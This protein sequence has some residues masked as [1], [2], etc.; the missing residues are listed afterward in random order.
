VSNI[1]LSPSS[2]VYIAKGAVTVSL[3]CLLLSCGGTAPLLT[4]ASFD[5][6]SKI[7]IIPMRW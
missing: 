3:E 7:L 5:I 6:M 4:G 2:R 1:L